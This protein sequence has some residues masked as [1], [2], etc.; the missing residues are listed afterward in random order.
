VYS[1]QVLGVIGKNGTGKSTLL[2][3]IAGVYLPNG[4]E[5]KTDGKVVYLTGLHQGSSPKLTM[6]ENIY[7]MGSVMGLS[8]KEIKNRFA[9]IVEFSGLEKFVDMKIYQFSTG[10][11]SRLNFSI[12]MHCVKHQSPDILLLD[13]VLS[14]GGDID[15]KE[16]AT[17]KMEELIKGGATVVLVSHDLETIKKYCDRVICLE[18][19]VITKEGLPIEIVS[20]YEKAK[21]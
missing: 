20:E 16:K 6:A 15:F 1:G 5:V 17:K 18:S 8:Q 3:L 14:I 4:G 21:S 12:I 13:E 19:G 7:L 11:I 10:M 9:E 2:R